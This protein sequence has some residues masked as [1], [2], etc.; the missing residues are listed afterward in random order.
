MMSTTR[1]G[2]LVSMIS[3]REDL[4]SMM[5]TREDLVSMMSTTRRGDLVSISIRGD[6]SQYDEY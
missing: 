6:P 5:S 4:V 1:R 3:I 2:D